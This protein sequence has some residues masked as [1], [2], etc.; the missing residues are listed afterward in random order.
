M[1]LK[2]GKISQEIEKAPN[3][4]HA[5]GRGEQGSMFITGPA[6]SRTPTPP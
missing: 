1:N 4:A 6:P 5:Q 2:A 3:G